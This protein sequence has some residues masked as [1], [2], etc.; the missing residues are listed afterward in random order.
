MAASSEDISTILTSYII[1]CKLK[2]SVRSAHLGGHLWSGYSIL[3]NGVVIDVSRLNTIKYI[4]NDDKNCDK[5][6]LLEPGVTQGCA[7]QFTK[8][9]LQIFP[10]SGDCDQFAF[11]GFLQGGGLSL[12]LRSAGIGA[13]YIEKAEVVLMNGDIVTATKYNQY[14]DLLYGIKGGGAGNFGIITKYFMSTFEPA[15]QVISF[16]VYWDLKSFKSEK[17]LVRFLKAWATTQN[18]NN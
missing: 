2:F 17:K 3:D 18:D 14:S 13:D 11:G 5:L 7:N 8:P 10:T 15:T 6:I 16:E 1:P 9:Y 4:D 12:F